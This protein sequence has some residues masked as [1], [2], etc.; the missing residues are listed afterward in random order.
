MRVSHCCARPYTIDVSPRSRDRAVTDS[1]APVL[2]WLRR[3]LRLA[4]NP[5][6]C[7]AL[8]T[9]RPVVPVFVLDETSPDQWAPGGAS[10]WWLHH[11]LAALA[12]DLAG[13]GARLV[14]RRGTFAE[15]IPRLAAETGAVEIHAGIPTEP[16]ARAA[17]RRVIAA[18]GSVKLHA[19]LTTLLHHPDEI[20]TLAGTPYGV[21][22]PFGRACRAQLAVPMAQPA[23]ARIPAGPQPASD[24]LAAWNLLPRT[25]DW[26]GGLRTA[27]TPG[28]AGAQARLAAFVA[29]GLGQ[30][31]AHRDLPGCDGT[32][33]LSP[34]LAWGEISPRQLW[35]AGAACEKFRDEMLWREFAAHLLWHHPTLPDTPLRAEFAAMPWRDDPAALR[36]WQRGQ[37]GIPIVDAGMRQLWQTGWMHNR[38]RMIVASFLVKHLLLP[39]Q[40]GEKWFWDTLVDADLAQNAASWQWVAGSGADAAP[41]FRV[42]NPL[43]QGRKFDPDGAYVRRFVPE[44]AALPDNVIHAPWEAPSLL[45]AGAGVRL[46]TTYP[47]PV[48]DLAAGRARAL[49]A[50]AG[51][52]GA[53]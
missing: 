30:Y 42:F 25:P 33:R 8:A 37:T 20:R 29:E 34:H 49:L 19:H 9:G 11:S 5:A 18:L 48:I 45:L 27:W 53:A 24:D 3:D 28:E 44:L 43:L 40:H 7:A 26:A 13:R 12:A 50:F 47:H 10:R 46:G 4:D 51:L 39:W 2:L 52:R 1:S 21:F 35:H 41:Y 38:V 32:S 17:Y 36:A 23:P 31:R 15:V 14:L 22:T 16:W 6:L